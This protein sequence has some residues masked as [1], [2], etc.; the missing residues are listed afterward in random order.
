MSAASEILLSDADVEALTGY[1]I[2]TKQLQVLHRRGF[3]RAYINRRGQ[4]VLERSHYE[5]VSRGEA[6]A[7]AGQLKAANLTMF[8]QKRA[9]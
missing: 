9:A 6:A 3:H 1:S 8:R 7:Q 4:V 2:A 5:S